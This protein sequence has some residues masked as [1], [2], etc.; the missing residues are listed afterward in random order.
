MDSAMKVMVYVQEGDSLGVAEV[1]AGYRKYKK[2]SKAVEELYQKARD[3]YISRLPVRR[4]G[5]W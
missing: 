4:R 3:I 5:G 1:K 2:S